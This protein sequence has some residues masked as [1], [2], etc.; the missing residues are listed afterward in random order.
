MV[1]KWPLEDLK[2]KNHHFELA[3]S[4][5]AGGKTLKGKIALQLAMLYEVLR[6]Q[7]RHLEAGKAVFE[8]ALPTGKGDKSLVEVH[9][10]SVLYFNGEGPAGALDLVAFFKEVNYRSGPD[11]TGYRAPDGTDRTL[12][13]SFIAYEVK[14]SK[15]VAKA[16]GSGRR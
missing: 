13:Q 8:M 12:K 6:E 3:V 1:K 2:K 4:V 5:K 9:D 11:C 10:K 7:V 15:R 16:C 14:A